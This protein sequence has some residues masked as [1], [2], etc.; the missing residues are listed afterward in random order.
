MSRTRNLSD[1]LDSNGDVVS[2]ALD[3]VP[4]ADVV[5]D[6]TPQLGGDLNTNG[7]DIIV[8]AGDSLSLDSTSQSE[9]PMVH[10]ASAQLSGTYSQ[11]EISISPSLSTYSAYKMYVTAWRLAADGEYWCNYMSGSTKKGGWYGGYIRAGEANSTGAEG[12]SNQNQ[13]EI[14]GTN[15]SS[16]IGNAYT[17]NG[18]FTFYPLESGNRGKITWH[19]FSRLVT[20]SAQ[21]IVGGALTTDGATPDKI[22]FYSNQ[23]TTMFHYKLYGIKV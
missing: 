20:G 4:A 1:L 9:W 5:N 14:I 17:F 15:T 19:A 22:V 8:G 16:T 23:N 3:N 6:T 11:V 12:Y 10:L 18:E 2:G 13:C 7:N 21:N